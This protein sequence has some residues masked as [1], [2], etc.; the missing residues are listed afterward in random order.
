M[1]FRNNINRYC[2]NDG[3]QKNKLLVCT[4]PENIVELEEKIL[5]IN[6]CNYNDVIDCIETLR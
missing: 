3:H 4:I 2:K 5:S 1:I 6:N